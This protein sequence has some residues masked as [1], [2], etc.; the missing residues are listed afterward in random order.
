[1]KTKHI[2]SIALAAAS[3][4]F[5]SCLH[6][7]VGDKEFEN[8]LTDV[9][10]L[11]GE[12][13][14]KFSFQADG[15]KVRVFN[16]TG[17]ACQLD[18]MVG[19]T[20]L[21]CGTEN[22]VDVVVPFTGDLMFSAKVFAGSTFVDVDVPVHVDDITYE[23]SQEFYTLANGS[24][25]GKKWQWW[26]GYDYENG[27]YQY[28]DGSWGPFGGGGYGWSATGPN[29]ECFGIGQED[30]WTGQM[31]SMDE[32]V[33][34]DLDGGANVTV[35]YSDGHEATGSFA[36]E[37]F[38]TPAKAALG[39]VGTIKI[40]GVLL[41]HQVDAT[42]YSWYLAAGLETFD[43]AMLDDEHMII[44]GPGDGAVLC[45]PNWASSSTHWTFQAVK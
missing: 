38:T 24:A 8:A 14:P 18:Y 11:A 29:W 22:Y 41:P 39:W 26:V 19:K 27:N 3:M 4:S 9:E 10:T 7:S 35:H 45:D 20:F 34:F 37:M 12:F 15:N 42:Q 1:M 32:W 5:T 16:N 44:I 31:M 21:N 13:T 6:T 43:L 33:K 28:I 40:S 25:E 30:A 2:L 23:L 17:Y 36:V